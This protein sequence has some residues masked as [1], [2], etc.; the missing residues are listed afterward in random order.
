M[1]RISSSNRLTGIS[2]HPLRGAVDMPDKQP[3]AVTRTGTDGWEVVIGL[4]I[5]VQLSTN[6][7][8]FSGASTKFGAEPNTQACAIDL[9]MPGVLP[10]VNA[11]VYP[12]AIAFGLGVGAEIGN[13]SAFDRKNYFYPDLPKGYQIT[14]MDYPIVLGG[15]VDILL[16]SGATKTINLTRAHLEEDAGKS[17][18]EDFHGKTGVDLNRAGTPLLEI[19]S[20]PD[21]SSATEAVTYAKHIHQLVTY[22]GVSDGDMSQGSLR[23]D[24][25]VSIRRPGDSEL[26]TRTETKNVNSF[27]FL[28]RA[29]LYEIERQI[30]VLESGRR[31][32]QETRLYDPARDETR[33]MR[34][35]ETA[36]DYR[37]FPEPDLLPVVIDETYIQAVRDNMPELPVEKR[38]RF[39]KQYDLSGADAVVLTSTL[40]LANYFEQ[41][42]ATGN[43]PRLAANWVRVELLGKL[44]KEG[45]ELGDAPV[46]A[47]QLGAVVMRIRDNTISGTMAKTVFEGLWS[48]QAASADEYIETHGLQQVSGTDELWPIVTE[49]I[50][51]NPN[52]AEQFRSGK[53][54]LLGFFV[55][56]VMKET[57]GKANPREVSELVK[58]ALSHPKS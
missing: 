49:I 42:A 1:L 17:L 32:T 26:G 44:N 18:H 19:V 15:H 13:Y 52:Q 30:G 3:T 25:N 12:K 11:E 45:M 58:K 22:L 34:S 50:A 20:E 33:P 29:I 39:E 46:S 7:K 57:Q 43:D 31:V 48:G 14:Q 10:V 51:A 38:I 35:K 37:Y 2:Y 54:K 40:Q 16:D 36:T 5:H 41:V 9:G 6:S 21:M 56:Q 47:E 27:R 23:C 24:A 4:E 55:G 28:E 8:I 53:T